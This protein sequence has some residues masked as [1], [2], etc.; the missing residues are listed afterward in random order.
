MNAEI[1]PDESA[2]RN[3]RYKSRQRENFEDGTLHE[4][5]I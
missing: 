2:I 4:H 3:G 5:K 1:E